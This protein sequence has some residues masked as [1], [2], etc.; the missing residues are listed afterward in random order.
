M[1]G[2]DAMRIVQAYV[3]EYE[4]IDSLE[5]FLSTVD[6]MNESGKLF[7][8]YGKMFQGK[9]PLVSEEGSGMIDVT[10]TPQGRLMSHIGESLDVVV[11]NE[12]KEQ[13]GEMDELVVSQKLY[14]AVVNDAKE[15]QK[16]MQGDIHYAFEVRAT[17]SCTCLDYGG[18]SVWNPEGKLVYDGE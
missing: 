5:S 4:S 13:P 2:T 10:Y 7:N 1:L 17:A 11:A 6:M 14:D 3:E 12:E 18:M 8:H 16:S 15:R 9:L